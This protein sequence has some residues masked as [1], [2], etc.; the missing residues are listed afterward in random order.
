MGKNLEE[1]IKQSLENYPVE[2]NEADWLDMQKKLDANM[3]QNTSGSKYFFWAALCS[4]TCLTAL[5]VY[6]NRS[7]DNKTPNQVISVTN[8]TIVSDVEKLNHE[9]RI[10]DTLKEN[11]SKN[12]TQNNSPIEK[13]EVKETSAF[14][15]IQTIQ[16]HEP[17]YLK[18]NTIHDEP[19]KQEIHE[20]V[21]ITNNNITHEN[22]LIEI[23]SSNSF[24]EMEW[25]E[26]KVQGTCVDCIYEWSFGD[27]N[28]KKGKEVKHTYSSFG[29]YH[30]TLHV[31]NSSSLNKTLEK[32][33]TVLPL[34]QEIIHYSI[35]EDDAIP[36]HTFKY[37]DALNVKD[38]QWTFSDNKLMKGAEVSNIYYD[39]KAEYI[40]IKATHNNGCVK[41]FSKSYSIEK[42]FDLLAPNAFTPNGSGANDTWMPKLLQQR[43]FEFTL[44]IYDSKTRKLVYTTNNAQ[45]GWDGRMLGTNQQA[46]P[47]QTFIWE[48]NVRINNQETRLF[49]GSIIVIQ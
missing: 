41:E 34:P 17:E 42:V 21:K 6:W 46:K 13:I 5:F 16:K 7:N 22:P 44:N 4:I 19:S 1:L 25:S 36:V 32:S 8:N 28:S 20:E 27:G 14:Q 49:K 48:A 10:N 23:E 9:D 3:P 47:Q 29:N 39:Q 33:I 43:D 11:P 15:N 45:K 40:K 2:Y 37:E 18:P 26:F 31:T 30:V 12:V 24:C 38:V 35:Q